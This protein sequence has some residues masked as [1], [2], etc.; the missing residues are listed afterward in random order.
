M[1]IT[2]WADPGVPPWVNSQAGLVSTV[3]CQ[4][5]STV[6]LMAMGENA[7]FGVLPTHGSERGHEACQSPAD[8]NPVSL[9]RWQLGG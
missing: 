1:L 2:D 7:A 5:R 8:A 4:Y 9:E 3:L 6:R